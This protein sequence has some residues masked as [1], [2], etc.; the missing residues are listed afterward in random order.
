MM[1][2]QRI[3]TIIVVTLVALLLSA[4]PVLAEAEIIDFTGTRTRT[5][6]GGTPPE[7]VGCRVFRTIWANWTI[8]TDNYLVTGQWSNY[9]SKVNREVLEC[10]PSDPPVPPFAL[11]QGIIIGPFMLTPDADVDGGVWE[12]TWKIFFRP[13]GS[14]LVTAEAKGV[15]G[16]LEGLRLKARGV[17]GLVDRPFNGSVL[18]PASADGG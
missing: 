2:K 12:G 14:S 4:G 15:G 5:A 17:G 13:D 10:D 6:G 9:D 1:K 3:F 8:T 11:G 7:I 18:I 16:D